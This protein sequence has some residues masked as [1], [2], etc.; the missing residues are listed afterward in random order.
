MPVGAYAANRDLMQQM[1]PTGPIYQAGTLSGNPIAM[2]AGIATLNA[3][4]SPGFFD[5]LHNNTCL[6][7]DGL[8]EVANKAK[9]PLMT[10]ALGGMF[11]LFFTNS[12][13]IQ[14]ACD[15]K[16]AQFPH[17]NTLFH[18]LL[19]QGIYMA[20]SAFEAGFVSIAHTPEHFQATWS[21][22]E[23]ALAGVLPASVG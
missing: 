19:D 10:N 17:F 4:Q 12:P 18:H 15:V 3:I 7:V 14:N 20:P 16:S 23:Q 13:E 8:R 5:T 1:A 22:F 2:S 21:A 11:G 6:L 9:V